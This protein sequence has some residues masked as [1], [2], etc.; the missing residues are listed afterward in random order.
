[1]DHVAHPRLIVSHRDI[2]RI[3]AS[4]HSDC[5]TAHSNS[6]LPN[7]P[8]SLVGDFPL[9]N[10]AQTYAWY[11]LNDR[12]DTHRCD[13]S[14][15][16]VWDPQWILRPAESFTL[17]QCIPD[18]SS[19][20][21][22]SRMRICAND[23]ALIG[24]LTY[25]SLGCV[26]TMFQSG[27]FELAYCTD[28][29]VTDCASSPNVISSSTGLPVISSLL[30]PDIY[31]LQKIVLGFEQNSEY[32]GCGFPTKAYASATMFLWAPFVCTRRMQLVCSADG[33]TAYVAVFDNDACDGAPI[34][35]FSQVADGTTCINGWTFSC[36]PSI[37]STL[38]YDMNPSLPSVPIYYPYTSLPS[39]IDELFYFP[40]PS[41]FTEGTWSGLSGG[42]TGGGG[43]ESVA[44]IDFYYVGSDCSSA[45]GVPIT[46]QTGT[47]QAGLR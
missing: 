1:M 5:T 28:G 12:A 7:Q 33:V 31:G 32:G 35:Q 39:V 29:V 30:Q 26:D 21:P 41:N 4:S 36:T 10:R 47:V 22:T 42:A 37:S 14:S 8:I 20:S 23:G 25:A 44:Q 16:G 40:R 46:E 15:L 45:P 3:D 9:L 6:V 19:S 13:M 2:I 43:G 34:V 27:V 38:L 11:S 18:Y 24:T 17:G